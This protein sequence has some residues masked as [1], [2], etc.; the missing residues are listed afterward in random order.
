VSILVFQVLATRGGWVARAAPTA[1]LALLF[2]FGTG[3]TLRAKTWQS[4]LALAQNTLAQNPDNGMVEFSYAC[5]LA[6]LGRSEDAV[7]R[8]ERAIQLGYVSGPAKILGGRAESANKYAEAEK[9][10]LMA[11]WPVRMPSMRGARPVG[12]LGLLGKKD[13]EIYLSL[14]RL[15]QSMALD[16]PEREKYHHERIVHFH[17]AACREGSPDDAYLKYLLAKAHQKYGDAAKAKSLFAQVRDM[18]P[19]TY[20]GKAAGKMAEPRKK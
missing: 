19:D 12:E 1:V 10:Y 3:T 6:E 5:A 14:A 16:E 7:A 4:N 18:A 17:E 2:I 8:W 20:Y 11:L 9:Y 15:H 13:P